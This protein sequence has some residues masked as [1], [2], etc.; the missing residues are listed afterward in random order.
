MALKERF[1]LPADFVDPTTEPLPAH[2]PDGDDS[3]EAQ[4]L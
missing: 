1:Q 3:S 2:M 4:F